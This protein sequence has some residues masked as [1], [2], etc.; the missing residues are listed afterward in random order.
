MPCCAFAAFL[1]GQLLLGLA[2][3]KRVFLGRSAAADVPLNAAVE[4]RLLPATGSSPNTPS[5]GWPRRRVWTWTFAAAALIEA[6][7][8]VGAI[9]LARTH[10]LHTAAG[11]QSNGSSTITCGGH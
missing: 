7:L 4:W 6:A 8:V 5:R 11:A 2:A 9:Q 1:L 10:F 3:L